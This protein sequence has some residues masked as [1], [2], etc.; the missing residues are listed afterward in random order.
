MSF[1]SVGGSVVTG[2]SK[3]AAK[4]APNMLWNVETEGV[5]VAVETGAGGGGAEGESLQAT[6]A[7]L[8]RALVPSFKSILVC[9]AGYLLMAELERL[10]QHH[11]Q[12]VATRGLAC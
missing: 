5:G 2:A 11:V 12:N 1:G 8:K 9:I 10:R 6:S 7:E 3:I 4:A